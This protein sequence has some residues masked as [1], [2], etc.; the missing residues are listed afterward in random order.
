L[1][2]T[3]DNFYS[4]S[5][6]FIKP[7]DRI[8]ALKKKKNRLQEQRAVYYFASLRKNLYPLDFTRCINAAR[9][10]EETPQYEKT[11]STRRRR[12]SRLP[13]RRLQREMFISS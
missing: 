3:S 8:D 12:S 1:F 2:S 7:T 6:I 4:R 11:L 13:R 10:I 5:A 9:K